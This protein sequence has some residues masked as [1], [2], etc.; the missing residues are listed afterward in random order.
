MAKLVLAFKDR[1][2]KVFALAA[3]DCLIGRDQECT[4]VIDS[5]AVEPHHAR[6]HGDQDGKYFV[7]A[8]DSAAVLVNDAPISSAHEL[9]EG[10]QIGIGKHTL[11]FSM[12]NT[13]T[14]VQMPAPSRASGLGWLQILNGNH[15]GRTIRLDKAFTRIGKPDRQLAIIARR[16]NGHYVS[17]LQGDETPRVNGEAIGDRTLPLRHGDNIEVGD[18][19]VQFFAEAAAG[20]PAPGEPQRRFSRIAFDVAVTLELEQQ[21]WRTGLIDISL[22]GALIRMP[23]NCT[24][25]DGA[26]CRLTVHLEGGPDIA[27]DASVAH[28]EQGHL[29]LRCEHIDVDS[30]SCLRRLVELNLGDA[31]L[32]ERELAALG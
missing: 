22:H 21:S 10:D 12:E 31:A 4:I 2:L 8:I 23:E 25:A 18:L 28:R 13:G 9:Q 16:D 29:G 26:S 27:M 17:H 19:K 3:G 11:D 30:I 7:E 5:L 15:L 6:I 24:P 14:L 32:V 1:K 20:S